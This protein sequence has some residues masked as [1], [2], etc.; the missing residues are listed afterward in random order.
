MKSH[1]LKRIRES[2]GLTQQQLADVLRTTRVS[3]ARCEVGM[4][5][6][7]GVVR[8]VLEQLQRRTEIPMAGI[9]A[10]RFFVQS[11]HYAE[12]GLM[13]GWSAADLLALEGLDQMGIRDHGTINPRLTFPAQLYRIAKRSLNC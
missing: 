8:V 9:V 3:V 13:I 11:L 4:W 12:I 6:I 1:D 2:L 7:P 10:A 5:R